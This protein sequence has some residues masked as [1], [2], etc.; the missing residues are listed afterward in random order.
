MPP[1][2]N[3]P[4]PLGLQRAPWPSASHFPSNVSMASPTETSP[5]RVPPLRRLARV[6]VKMGPTGSTGR[7]V[8]SQQGGLGCQGQSLHDVGLQAMGTYLR[9]HGPPSLASVLPSPAPAPR[10]DGGTELPALPWWEFVLETP[11]WFLCWVPGRAGQGAEARRTS[12]AKAKDQQLHRP[13]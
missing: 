2:G 4:P 9:T 6:W 10:R 12:L 8:H 7:S 1:Q 11:G 13:G 3:L 5:P